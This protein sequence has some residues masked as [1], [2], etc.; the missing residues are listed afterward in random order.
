MATT[1]NR[2]SSDAVK[3]ATGMSWDKWIAVLD[4]AGAAKMEHKD[5][6]R[7]LKD[8]GLVDSPWWQQMVTVGYEIAKGLRVEGET[9]YAGFEIGVSKTL[10][11]SPKQAWELIT[12]RPG[13]DAWLGPIA[14]LRFAKGVKYRT[15]DGTTGEIRSVTPGK[16][17]R[18]TWQPAVWSTPSTIGIHVVP[19]GAKTSI[20][21]HQEKLANAK[22]RTQMRRQWKKTLDALERMSAP[23]KAPKGRAAR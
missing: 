7:L 20:R 3:R 15:T 21:F 5:I 1:I 10:P 12:T 8:Q 19:A 9:K 13:R 16:A 4:R 23:A 17:L 6:A 2:V 14:R 18:L 11:I 22:I